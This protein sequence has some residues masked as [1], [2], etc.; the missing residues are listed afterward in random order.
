[1]SHDT[2]R[3]KWKNVHIKTSKGEEKFRIASDNLASKK[4]YFTAESGV[5]DVTEKVKEEEN[6]KEKFE[7]VE[8]LNKLMVGRELEMIKMKEEASNLEHPSL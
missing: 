6:L 2:S 7:E 8:K 4:S 1:M 3:L 5:Q